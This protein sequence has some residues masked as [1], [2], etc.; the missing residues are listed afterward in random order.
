MSDE[1]D[2]AELEPP[3]KKTRVHADYVFVRSFDSEKEALEYVKA[4]NW[5]KYYT[6]SSEA[7]MR[8]MLR[9]PKVKFR[10]PQCA[11]KA[12]LLYDSTNNQIHFYKT[13]AEHDHE[14]NINAVY[15]IPENTKKEIKNMFDLGVTRPKRILNNLMLRQ[16]ELPDKKK[17]DS[18]LRELKTEKFGQSNIN[19]IDLKIWLENNVVIPIDKTKPF[20]VDFNLSLNESNPGFK[21]FVSTKQLLALATNAPHVHVDGTYKLVWQGY[22][23]IQIGNTDMHRSFHPFGLGVC[24]SETSADYTFIFKAVKKGVK[25]VYN[26]DYH[27]KILIRDGALSIQ[28]GFAAVF[29]EDGA[30]IMCWAH[31]R[32]KM[33][34][35]M[36][37]YIHNKKERFELLADLDKL[38]LS[39][40]KETFDKAAYLFVEKWKTISADAM[41]Y[42]ELEWLRKNRFWYEGVEIN[43]PSTNNA[44]EVANRLI[45]D[46]HTLRERFDLGQFRTVLFQMMESWSLHY[47][48]GEKEFH[49]SPEIE[50]KQWTEAYAWAKRN[51]CMKVT[52]DTNRIVYKIPI[53][54]ETTSTNLQIDEWNSFEDFKANNFQFNYVVFP[55]SLTKSNW[56]EGKCDCSAF[57]KVYMCEH[58]L[59]ISLRMKFVVA[60]D[61][62]KS[63]PLGQKRK[64]GR[65]ARAKAALV[66]Q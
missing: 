65:P 54:I 7:G 18:F 33:V 35:N 11:A 38:Q 19:L 41:T 48:T 61:E 39:K 10:G 2:E 17:L 4:G 60:P 52:E 42:F 40:N 5:S 51:V 45:K 3:R 37:K 6:S 64:R 32:R 22:P 27:P 28:N 55:A 14:Q 16:I 58:V 59:G 34:E 20:I 43:T 53:G 13:I 56:N 47:V 49:N 66:I 57:F 62:A 9:C 8:Q 26:I 44:V 63:L 36:P 25:D 1:Q 30:S 46:E 29:G 12:Y 50:L 24:T 15:E 31:M 21:F 23:V